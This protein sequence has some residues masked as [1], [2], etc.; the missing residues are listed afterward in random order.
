[1]VIGAVVYRDGS[2]DGDAAEAANY[3]AFEE[4]RKRA[5][6]R[7]VP[8]LEKAADSG[9]GSTN[10]LA[11]IGKVDLITDGGPQINGRASS[12]AGIAFEDVISDALVQLRKIGSNFDAPG[13]NEN[14]RALK[15]MASFYFEWHGRMKK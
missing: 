10:L 3:L 8:M 1:M 4:G 5:L 15:D 9:L 14:A 13:G 12:A 7:L 2:I 11:L 6:D